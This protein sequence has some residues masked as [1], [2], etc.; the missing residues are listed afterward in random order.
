MTL[1]WERREAE[2]LADVLC[3]G[4]KF[5]KDQQRM[6]DYFMA[7]GKGY[8]LVPRSRTPDYD[9]S[10]NPHLNSSER[11]NRPLPSSLPHS[12][13]PILQRHETLGSSPPQHQ[14]D[15]PSGH[16]TLQRCSDPLNVASPQPG[17]TG[18]T[19]PRQLE[20]SPG[21]VATLHQPESPNPF[22]S[23]PQRLE[24][25]KPSEAASS[26]PH[27]V[28][29]P[30][31]VESSSSSDVVA[32]VSDLKDC[33]LQ[34]AEKDR[35]QREEETNRVVSCLQEQTEAVKRLTDLLEMRNGE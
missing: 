19:P 23:L 24:T 9:P 32:A 25:H 21:H 2:Q 28:A 8:M 1:Q 3:S 27:E 17:S 33:L 5:D 12:G 26:E 35:A 10:L 7:S 20:S 16:P 31:Q 29:E 22:F 34:N 18:N 4:A 11:P 13:H 15:T 6:Y 30:D 14:P